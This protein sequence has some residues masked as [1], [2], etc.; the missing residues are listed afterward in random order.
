MGSALFKYQS[1]PECLSDIGSR[2][3]SGS[4]IE[5][6]SF[7]ALRFR[8]ISENEI[9]KGTK[10]TNTQLKT[11]CQRHGVVWT[12]SPEQRLDDMRDFAFG[13]QSQVQQACEEIGRLEAELAHA[14]ELYGRPLTKV[15]FPR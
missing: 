9:R 4:S 15:V 8:G 14:R 6:C 3:Q 2:F 13:L 12:I 10:L 1:D 11:A 7:I 5:D